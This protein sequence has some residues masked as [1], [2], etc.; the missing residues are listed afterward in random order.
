MVH[1]V[2]IP[3]VGRSFYLIIIC[4]C[5]CSKD[6]EWAAREGFKDPCST[7]ASFT[8]MSM[9]PLLLQYTRGNNPNVSRAQSVE[10]NIYIYIFFHS[11]RG[12]TYLQNFFPC[13]F[14][15]AVSG[16]HFFT[17][18]SS[19]IY[20]SPLNFSFFSRGHT[21]LQDSLSGQHYFTILNS[22][23]YPISLNVFTFF[24]QQ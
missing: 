2:S 24:H 12:D 23:I 14:V 4:N 16:Q 10:C 3:M 20:P 8:L 22:P 18:L 7:T 13:F 21:Y 11:S 15:K 19:Q 6:P 5:F 17:T 9:W 1:L